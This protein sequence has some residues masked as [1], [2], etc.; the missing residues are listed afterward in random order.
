MDVRAEV[1]AYIRKIFAPEK[2][3]KTNPTKTFFAILIHLTFFCDMS[4]FVRQ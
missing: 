3:T 2:A 1:A 4:G